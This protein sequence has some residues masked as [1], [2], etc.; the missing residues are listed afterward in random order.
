VGPYGAGE[1]RSKKK[2]G[3]DGPLGHGGKSCI[4]CSRY[5]T[6]KAEKKV[7]GRGMNEKVTQLNQESLMKGKGKREK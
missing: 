3:R 4:I 1:E 5:E 7:K 6:L 2:G